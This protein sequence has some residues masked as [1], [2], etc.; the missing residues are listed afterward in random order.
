MVDYHDSPKV[1][2][3]ENPLWKVQA[4]IYELNKQAKDMWVTG[5]FITIN[6][7]TSGFQ[8]ASGLKLRISYKRE[9]DGFQCD[10]VCDLRYT[11]AFVFAM[12]MP[13]A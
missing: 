13:G 11:Y 6:E 10:A 12:A 5:V 9:G 3:K 2:Q 7:Q 4:L 1:K 8:G